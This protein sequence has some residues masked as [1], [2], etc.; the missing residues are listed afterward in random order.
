MRVLTIMCKNIVKRSLSSVSLLLLLSLFSVAPLSARTVYATDNASFVGALGTNLE[1]HDTIV[2][3]N[4][5]DLASQINV[6][7]VCY[8]D[9]NGRALSVQSAVFT[10]NDTLYLFDSQSL[11][12]ISSVP[13]MFVAN[14]IV[15]VSRPLLPR[16]TST[17]PS[18]SPIYSD[19]CF[20][21]TDYRVYGSLAD[22][23]TSVPNKDTVFLVRD[24]VNVGSSISVPV[25]DTVVIAGGKIV[26]AAKFASLF[27][28][29]LSSMLVFSSVVVDGNASLYASTS[30]GG[31]VDNS[32]ALQLSQGSC[33]T[34][35][36]A[37]G[38]GACVASSGTIY[39]ED[40]SKIE[41]VALLPNGNIFCRPQFC[42]TVSFT[43]FDVSFNAIAPV[44]GKPLTGIVS[45]TSG[46][47]NISSD[48]YPMYALRMMRSDIVWSYSSLFKMDTI[49]LGLPSGT[50]WA[51]CNL[52]AVRQED[53]GSYFSWGELTAYDNNYTL[54]INSTLTS[55]NDVATVYLGSGWRMPSHQELQELIEATNYEWTEVAGVNGLKFTSRKDPSQSLFLPTA[56]W[57]EGG[58]LI[59]QGEMGAFWSRDFASKPYELYASHSGDS[60][61]V[62]NNDVPTIG[63]SVR[64]VVNRTHF[65]VTVAD[66]EGGSVQGVTS[67]MYPFGSEFNVEAVPD[68]G[69]HFVCW[70]YSAAQSHHVAPWG[71]TVLRPTFEKNS[72]LVLFL[73]H[74][75][76]TIKKVTLLFA[77]TIKLPKQPSLAG[78]TFVGWGQPV[79]GHL[80]D[81]DLVFKATYSQNYY[82][83]TWSD[84]ASLVYNGNTRSVKAS[85]VN[86]SG[87]TI[88][89]EIKYYKNGGR[90]S[91]TFRDAAT[92]KAVAIV[93][94]DEYK[95][96]AESESIFVNIAKAPLTVKGVKVD[97]VKM[98]D[99]TDNAVVVDEG[100]VSTV[101]GADDVVVVPSA[102]FDNADAG[103]GK[104]VM[105]T[106]ALQGIS[107]SNYQVPE[108]ILYS[109]T[110]RILEEFSVSSNAIEGNAEG[111]CES[112]LFVINYELLKGNPSFYR[113]QFS[114]AAK[115][116][117]FEDV[118]WTPTVNELQGSV[119][120]KVPVTCLFGRYDAILQ[121]KNEL[122]TLSTPISV[123]F[124]INISTS[125]LKR[126][127]DDVIA[128]DL[129]K[130]QLQNY[131]WYR[132]DEF[133]AGANDFYYQEKGGL[134]GVYYVSGLY[135]GVE[136]R[137]C[138][139][140]NLT[141][142]EDP[143]AQEVS[144]YPNP[145]VSVVNVHISGDADAQHA[146][147]LVNSYGVEVRTAAFT[148]NNASLSVD[149]LPAGSYML[150]VDGVS[151]RIVVRH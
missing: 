12:S 38:V 18:F 20:N 147:R 119:L 84:T 151:H 11:G 131:Q 44:L 106:Y 66:V 136:V 56:G 68:S 143:N 83:V 81:K 40:S 34:N 28:I 17:V 139:V 85:Y 51:S 59:R 80:P 107:S 103:Y 150:V 105:V 67:G 29:P 53:N 26:R 74:T 130:L 113:L 109:R 14:K 138:A 41:K 8:I 97:D 99:G 92:Y 70:N 45:A 1:L 72:H 100:V 21:T 149:A 35:S 123:S 65:K 57:M 64:P 77:D 19:A 146:L 133:V 62:S 25:A 95:F 63:Q 16:V 96:T 91:S 145:A 76:D 5:I 141:I 128:L 108:P 112:D 69:Y 42:G 115:A 110:G 94:N 86:D 132:N 58:I 52:G 117:G 90:F 140:E 73:S 98:Y 61:V 82:P 127:F 22:V 75:G 60:I 135:N 120:I 137:S 148:G 43:C 4:D 30:K 2:L 88:T 15:Y 9:L 122:D 111:Y 6:S 54:N 31:I 101:F 89:L 102:S 104:R 78:H 13:N 144:C 114:D 48:L 10:V 121:F 79:P 23:V 55:A 116:Q 125:Y 24:V 39:M 129:N 32:G 36:S 46:I 71:D 49:D 27:N 33:F 126:V 7:K 37:S 93:D 50:L 118:D 134:S 87:R 142:E 124:V 47:E 3:D